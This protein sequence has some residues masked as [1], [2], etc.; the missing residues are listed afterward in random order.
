[1]LASVPVAI[2]QA[3]RAHHAGAWGYKTQLLKPGAIASPDAPKYWTH[4]PGDTQREAFTHAGLIDYGSWREVKWAC[5]DFGIE[6]LATPF[7]LSAVDALE[8][9]GVSYYKIASG[10]ITYR[11]LIESVAQTLKPII[12][13]TGAAFSSEIERALGWCGRVP[14]ILLACNLAYPTSPH[15]ANMGRI[16]TLRHVFPQCEVG[17]SDHVSLAS[18][19]LA[20]GALGSVMNEVHYTLDKHAPDC[21]DNAMALDPAGLAEYVTASNLGE[22]LRGSTELAPN[23]SEEPARY[24]ARRSLCAA[25]DIAR[26]VTLTADDLVALRPGDGIPP[27]LLDQMVGTITKRPIPAGTQV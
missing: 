11:Q 3:Y 7:D 5:D 14:V 13:S 12:L 23:V 17:W 27:Y 9:I 22:K 25:R 8:D 2:D 15:D 4:G 6:F 16:E 10:D 18:S 1:M 19:G 20:A 24:G 26:G 21:A